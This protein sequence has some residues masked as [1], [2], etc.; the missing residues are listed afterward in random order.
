MEPQQALAVQA[1]VVRVDLTLPVRQELLI[2]VV[3]VAVAVAVITDL[4]AVQELLF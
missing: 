1:V 2:L 3:A 4:T